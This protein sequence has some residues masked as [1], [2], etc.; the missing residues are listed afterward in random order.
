AMYYNDGMSKHRTVSAGV[1]GESSSFDTDI[2][3]PAS[4]YGVLNLGARFGFSKTVSGF[5]S[6]SYT[7]GLKSEKSDAFNLGVQA[8]F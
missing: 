7:S 6:Y 2:E 1:V 5:A 8:A 3:Q 4:S